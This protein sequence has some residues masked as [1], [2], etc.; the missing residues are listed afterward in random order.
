MKLQTKI[1]LFASILMFVMIGFVNTMIYFMF[2]KISTDNELTQLSDQTNTIVE[3]V[4]GNPDIPIKNLLEAFLPTNGMIR[5]IDEEGEEIIPTLTKQD[6][7]RQLSIHF[8]NQEIREVKQD[9]EGEYVAV[10]LKPM[11]AENGGIATLQVVSYLSSLSETMRTLLYVLIAASLFILIP[12]IIGSN[13]LSRFIL[14]PIKELDTT[15]RENIH[16]EKWKMIEVKRRSHD[17][18]YEMETTFNDMIH[19][20]KENFQKQ[21]AFVSNASHELKTPLAIVKSYAQLLKRRGQTHPEVFTEAVEAI[22]SEADRMEKL[23]QQMLL[24]AK[25]KESMEMEPI[26]LVELIEKVSAT[27]SNVYER[28]IQ[29]HS[30]I[31][32]I[33]VR[34]NKGQLEQ[35]VYILLDNAIKYSDDMIKV[36][37]FEQEFNAC[38]QVTDFGKGMSI[39]DQE[40]IFDRFYRVDK[41]RSRVT[42][43]SGLGLSIAKEIT[44]MH[45]GRLSVKSKENEGTTFT[46]TLPITS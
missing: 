18:L 31:P 14:R 2:F 35:V 8:S 19:H 32:V 9:N 43:G 7:Y 5:M 37:L 13:V 1:T 10:V 20:L 28:D 42:G 26:N 34:A 21:E 33:T 27:F 46:I 24:L 3:T 40:H 23:V 41:A 45:Q 12:T 36:L 17:E 6:E 4:N 38:L 29:F 15:M 44:E 39:E 22:D 25:R 16:E 30:Q 11:I